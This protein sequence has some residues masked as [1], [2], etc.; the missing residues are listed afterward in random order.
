MKVCKMITSSISGADQ[1]FQ[2]ATQPKEL[3]PDAVPVSRLDSEG[4]EIFAEW[5]P[6][7]PFLRREDGVFWFSARMISFC[8]APILVRGK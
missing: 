6:K 4:H 7:R 8:W 5:R 3:D 1:Q 2:N